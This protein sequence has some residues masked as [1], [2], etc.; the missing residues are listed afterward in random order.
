VRRSAY[1]DREY[2]ARKAQQRRWGSEVCACGAPADTLDHQP[3]L[4]LHDHVRNSGCC[5]LIP[6]CRRCN[7]RGGQRI[8]LV[9]R[10]RRAL[11]RVLDADTTTG[12][13]QW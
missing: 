7:C 1:G 10:R 8:A 3:P 11:V 2:R 9:R 13:R 4:A 6:A 12:S 5:E